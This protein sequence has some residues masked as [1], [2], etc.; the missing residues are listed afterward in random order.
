LVVADLPLHHTD[1][2]DRLLIAQA[3]S[4]PLHFLTADTELKRYSDLV[5]VV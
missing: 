1:P 4:E 5:I 3:M 2:F